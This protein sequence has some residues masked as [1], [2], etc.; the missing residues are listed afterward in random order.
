MRPLSA[1]VLFIAGVPTAAPQQTQPAFEVASIK[2]DVSPSPGPRYS[3]FPGFKAE[4]ATLKDLLMLAYD[5]RELQISGGP[6]WVNSER[7]NIEA[8]ADAK[9]SFDQRWMAGQKQR[10]QSL[11]Q[12]RFR[13]AMHR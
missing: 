3:F 6:D 7:Y 2:P 1:L 11:L 9:P 4:S 10:L 8:K 13:L 5:V 12:E